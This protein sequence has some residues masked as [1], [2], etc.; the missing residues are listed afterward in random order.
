VA[1]VAPEM[2]LH[3]PLPAGKDCH[4]YVGVG[5]PVAAMVILLSVFNGFE[6]LVKSMF[7]AFDPDILITATV[8]KTFPVERLDTARLRSLAEVEVFSGVLEENGLLEYQGKQYIGTLRGVDANFEKIVPLHEMIVSGTS[9][10]QFGELE[11]A[12]VGQTIAYNLSIRT[13]SYALMRVYAPRR[14]TFS[15]LL[16]IESFRR[17]SLFPAGVFALE[18]E[19]DQKYVIT[20][21]AFTQR[22][23]DYP[24]RWSSVMVKLK[25]GIDPNGARRQIAEALGPDFKVQTRYQQKAS[26]YKIMAYEKWGV[27]FISL[28]VLII[29]SFSVV[30]SLVMLIIEKR[31]DVRTLVTLGGTVRF[32]RSIFIREGMLISTIGAAGGMT[33]GTLFCV[34][35]Q[36]LGFIRIPAETFLVDAYPVVIQAGDLLGIAATFLVV[37]VII[38]TFTTRMMIPKSTIVL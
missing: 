26:I 34:L 15:T 20:P 31:K 16:P 21:I 13:N 8:G 24:G 25:P 23:F 18:A 7:K 22:L 14:G 2:L 27:F 19:T 9:E 12:I 32:I 17:E 36:Q 28:L 5:V 1:D 11:Q 6:G 38:A 33:L 30:G 29:A 37:N 35:Q 3:V 10:L 4:W